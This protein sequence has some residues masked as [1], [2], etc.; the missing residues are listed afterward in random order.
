MGSNTP[1]STINANWFYSTIHFGTRSA[2]EHISMC[3][4]DINLSADGEG[5]EY[6]EEA[7]AIRR[8]FFPS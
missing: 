5:Q 6:L 2:E 7:L 1:A 8:I 3:L 4:G